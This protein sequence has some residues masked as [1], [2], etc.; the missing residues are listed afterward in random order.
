MASRG[1][2]ALGA[3]HD[4]GPQPAHHPV[5]PVPDERQSPLPHVHRNVLPAS[6]PGRQD[7]VQRLSAQ[8]IGSYVLALTEE[9]PTNEK[10]R[11]NT[12]WC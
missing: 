10:S 5:R 8:A 12:W 1:R 11:I 3:P 2:P 4:G 7:P 9:S 6:A